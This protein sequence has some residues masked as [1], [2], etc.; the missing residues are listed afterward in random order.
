MKLGDS[1]TQDIL[2]SEVVARLLADAKARAAFADPA[3]RA[4]LADAMVRD[5][6]VDAT[7]RTAIADGASLELP[8]RSGH[9]L[10]LGLDLSGHRIDWATAELAEVGD[11]GSLTFR[12]GLD[13]D[14]GTTVVAGGIRTR[15]APGEDTLRLADLGALR[16]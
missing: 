11:D 6:M 5:A 2:Q 1:A 14:G 10:P 9:I 16:H 3:V 8:P 4:A 15:L 7:F 13:P 12:P